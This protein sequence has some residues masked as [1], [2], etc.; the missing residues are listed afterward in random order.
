MQVDL[1]AGGWRTLTLD[2]TGAPQADSDASAIVRAGADWLEN[3]H[4]RVEVAPD[5]TVSVIDKPSGRREGPFNQFRSE[6]DR[7]D[8]YSFCPVPEDPPVTSGGSPATVTLVEEGPL[9]STLLIEQT[10]IVPRR[11][12]A[13]R[14]RRTDETVDISIQSRVSLLAG[15]RRVEFET[16][17]ENTAE[18]HRLR[19]LFQTG[20][21]TEVADAQGQFEVVRRPIELAAEERTRVPEFDE[22]QEVS[23]H[24]QRAI[25]DVSD[26]AGGVA[27]LNRGLPEYE[28]Q[29]GDDGVCL[30]LTLLRCVGW[31]SRGDLSTRYKHAGPALQTPAA[32]CPGTHRFHYAVVLH[33]GDWLAGDVPAE[34]EA[35]VTPIYRAALPLAASALGESLPTEMGWYCFGPEAL[36]YS[37]CKR[38]EDGR[39]IVLRAYNTTSIPVTGR[40]TTSLEGDIRLA[41]LAERDLSMPLAHDPVE[42]MTADQSPFATMERTV[43]FPV[44]AHE[45]V[46]LTIRPANG[47]GT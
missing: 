27:L 17:V 21:Q 7:G 40:L 6:A 46:T 36:R 5:G 2:P 9:R 23:Y 19:A 33:R 8:E 35:Y 42:S 30:G 26:A 20:V 34:A 1:P 15:G 32:Q 25:V 47:E 39:S 22:E 12:V 28:A 24:P 18:D 4:V 31:L 3:D 14:T 29:S 41:N 37:A 11:L 43:H 10:L 38:G 13:D 16:T 45:I 44:R